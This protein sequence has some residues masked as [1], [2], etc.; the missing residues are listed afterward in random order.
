MMLRCKFTH[1]PLN[2]EVPDG[3]FYVPQDN[4]YLANLS[5]PET[6]VKYLYSDGA[7]SCIIVIIAG[8]DALKNPLVAVSHLSSHPHFLQFFHLVA[9]HFCGAIAV[10]AQGANPPDADDSKHNIISLL[11]WLQAHSKKPPTQQAG[12]GW[13]INQI[14]LTLGTGHP[15]ED[16]RG[17]AGIDLATLT[18]SNQGYLFTEAQRDPTGGVQS[19]FSIFG[20]TI[21]PPMALHN[22]REA[23]H[24]KQIDR[25]VMQ[26]QAYNWTDILDM[27]EEQVLAMCSSTPEYEAPWFYAMLRNSALYVKNYGRKI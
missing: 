19:L 25:L 11:R 9:K 14:T 27:T 1:E 8:Q 20:L 3:L 15:Q 23:F 6:T 13:Y 21:E 7:T 16:N 26:A 2:A 5:T 24:Q 10:F 12:T 18:V 17:C 4:Y 22:A